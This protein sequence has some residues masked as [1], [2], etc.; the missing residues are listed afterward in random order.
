M[1]SSNA[2]STGQAAGQAADTPGEKAVTAHGAGAVDSRMIVIAVNRP[3][4]QHGL[5]HLL[6]KLEA[7]GHISISRSVAQT[8]QLLQRS[9]VEV[10]LTDPEH[11]SQL[12]RADRHALAS[13]RTLVITSR[14]HAGEDAFPRQ[15]RLCG[16]LTE[17]GCECSARLLLL[18]LL[19]C[20]FSGA[21]DSRC[22]GCVLQETLK[23]ADLPLSPREFEIFLRIGEGMGPT[24]IASESGLSVKTVE[25][26]REKIKQKLQLQGRDALLAASMRWRSGYFI[27]IAPGDDAD[28]PATHHVFSHCSANCSAG[29]GTP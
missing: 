27:Q 19:E 3:L 7:P 2:L 22:G 10:L 6:E 13:V 18:T 25:S 15:G 14:D 11:A 16:M 21:E 29:S 8:S 24:Q 17:K 9:N 4:I 12:H 23:K 5:V 26:Y 28:S 1:C 20:R